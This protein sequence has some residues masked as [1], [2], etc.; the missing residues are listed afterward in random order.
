MNNEEKILGLIGLCKRASKLT[1]GEQSVLENL[2]NFSSALVII[3]S[4]ASENTSKKFK[5]KCKTYH[6]PHIFF[7][8]RYTLGKYVKKE[9]AVVLSVNDKNFT[10]RIL[11]LY[12]RNSK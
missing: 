12:N 11:E 3:S 1:S 4:D 9:Y 8:D 2:R 10:N 7:S 6:T 5:D